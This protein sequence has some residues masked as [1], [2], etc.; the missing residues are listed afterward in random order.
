MA[1]AGNQA[2]WTFPMTTIPVRKRRP[3]SEKQIDD[4]IDD[5]FPASDPPSYSRTAR[6]GGPPRGEELNRVPASKV[7]DGENGDGANQD[8]AASKDRKE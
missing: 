3:R 4:T 5:S 2:S 6:S 1:T 8:E 7:K